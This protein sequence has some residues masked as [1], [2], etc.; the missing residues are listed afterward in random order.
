MLKDE[1]GLTK[2]WLRMRWQVFWV[3]TIMRKGQ[4]HG[5][6]GEVWGSAKM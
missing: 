5:S 2:Y 4:R 6:M 3:G 1:Q